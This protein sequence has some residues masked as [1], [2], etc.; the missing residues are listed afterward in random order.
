MDFGPTEKKGEKMA[1]KGEMGQ[2][3]A[4]IHFS[5]VFSPFPAGGPIWGQNRAIGISVSYMKLCFRN[6]FRKNSWLECKDKIFG[7][8]WS[9]FAGQPC[10]C[11]AR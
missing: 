3:R 2:K 6:S 7:T 10:V 9:E 4:K 11:R 8:G 5:A 1:E